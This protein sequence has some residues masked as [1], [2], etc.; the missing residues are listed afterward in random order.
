MERGP[1][2][3]VMVEGGAMILSDI[4]PCFIVE[5]LRWN[6]LDHVWDEYFDA[7]VYS[8]GIDFWN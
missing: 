5:Y 6:G 3:A 1:D 2:Q 8:P 4:K 7:Y